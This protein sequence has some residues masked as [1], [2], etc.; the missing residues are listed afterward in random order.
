MI[1]ECRYDF[2]KESGNFVVKEGAFKEKA[3]LVNKYIKDFENSALRKEMVVGE[4]YY[5]Q[6][7]TEIMKRA[8]KYYSES[9]GRVREDPYKANNK[10]A[11]GFSMLQTK[12]KVGFIINDNT[13]IKTNEGQDLDF[14]TYVKS[15]KKKIKSVAIEASKKA[16][17]YLMPL[18]KQVDDETAVL[19]FKLIDSEQIIPIPD[20]D[21]EETIAAYI[22][23]YKTS[24]VDSRGKTIEIYRAEYWDDQFVWYFSRTTK[25]NKSNYEK[26]KYIP[27]NPK[28]HIDRVIKYGKTAAN[29]E[30]QFWGRPP[31]CRLNNND[32]LRTDT[33]PIKRFIDAYDIMMSDFANNM[34]DFQDV[35][36]VLKNFGGQDADEVLS[37][38]KK[39]RL[40][41]TDEDGDAKPETIDI[42][43]EAREKILTILE[44]LIWK[45]G[46]GVNYDDIEGSPTATQIKF[47]FANMNL[48][49]NDFEIE[50]IE[51]WDQM[52][53]FIGR[54]VEIRNIAID[55]DGLQLKFVRQDFESENDKLNTNSGQM[56]VVDEKTRLSNHPWVKSNEVDDV[57]NRMKE[58]RG[59]II[60]NTNIPGDGDDE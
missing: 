22:R 50:L 58:D 41:A 57:I 20:V 54:F 2:N 6:M 39:D 18:I 56:G 4:A 28:P 8:M 47:M 9:A 33:Y 48:K 25:G 12:Q 16:V 23:Y 10:L 36:W 11:S 38:I 30:P 44:K 5:N 46:M 24:V 21:D 29:V 26:D 27:M 37:Q 1:C 59:A 15:T 43:H 42:P 51:L 34:E 7:N 19:K 55:I 60:L 31:I 53:Y 17:G 45:F 35:Y 49:V 40:I 3:A 32:E 14:E 13:I 52:K